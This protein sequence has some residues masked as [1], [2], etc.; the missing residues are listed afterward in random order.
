[1]L[2][3]LMMA[4]RMAP[5]FSFL[6]L[7]GGGAGSGVGHVQDCGPEQ[8]VPAHA[9]TQPVS[10]T[11]NVVVVHTCSHWGLAGTGMGLGGYAGTATLGVIAFTVV[12]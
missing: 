3:P 12:V 2:I 11:L 7:L 1:M 6:L 5:S 8:S 9:S 4:P 10:F